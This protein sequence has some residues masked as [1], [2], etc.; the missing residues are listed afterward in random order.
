MPGVPHPPAYCACIFVSLTLLHL[1]LAHRA[2]LAVATCGT[3][4]R[5]AAWHVMTPVLGGEMWAKVK[6]EACDDTCAG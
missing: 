3:C 6:T 2:R 1:H 5:G 4:K